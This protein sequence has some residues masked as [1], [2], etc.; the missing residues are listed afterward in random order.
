MNL[1][2]AVAVCLYELIR[3]G[4][5]V[6]STEKLEAAATS[7]QMERITTLLM[8]VLED[9][10]YLGSPTTSSA[11]EKIR[12]M[13]RRLNFPAQDADLWL[14]MLKQIEWKLRSYNKRIR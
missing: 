10:G 13:V 2:Q 14:G 7:E 5:R 3:A 12:R 1:G 11:E 8:G 9:S 4:G 6:P